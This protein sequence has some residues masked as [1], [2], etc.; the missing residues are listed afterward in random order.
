ML[1]TLSD[2]FV[3]MLVLSKVGTDFDPV[4]FS[5][6]IQKHPELV[7]THNRL[8]RHDLSPQ[9]TL[10]AP[11]MQYS[12]TSMQ[13]QHHSVSYASSSSSSHQSQ[14]QQ[15]Q[16]QAQYLPSSF[17]WTS[18]QLVPDN[19][20]QHQAQSHTQ[21]QGQQMMSMP[22]TSSGNYDSQNSQ[23]M[24]ES[25]S[26]ANGSGIGSGIDLPP[27]PIGAGDYGNGNS[28]SSNAGTGMGTGMW[29]TLG[30]NQQTPMAMSFNVAHG[31]SGGGGGGG[32]EGE[33]Q[34]QGRSQ[35]GQQS[36]QVQPMST[37]D[38]VLQHLASSSGS[39]STNSVNGN[40]TGTN[41][42]GLP[43][44]ANGMGIC[45]SPA[46]ASPVD[47][48]V[49]D[50]GAGGSGHGYE[51]RQNHPDSRNGSPVGVG[52]EHGQRQGGQES[53]EDGGSGNGMMMDQMMIT[54]LASDFGMRSEGGPVQQQQQHFDHQSQQQS[55]HRRSESSSG[56]VDGDG[57]YLKME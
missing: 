24:G 34:S 50:G 28:A 25:G 57:I 42:G 54:P 7:D 35:Q 21:D 56:G 6:H 48:A 43:S 18:G 5:N 16:T 20:G 17:N 8:P 44:F 37:P 32:A 29:T 49:S 4:G 2:D 53:V 12:T 10:E 15:A 11:P 38:Q 27:L 45:I 23:S 55:H 9:H 26:V 14:G 51:R 31:P 52:G 30:M 36:F 40:G 41:G 1:K 3:T 47:S 19:Y 33:P 13:Q 46:R 22:M 39:S